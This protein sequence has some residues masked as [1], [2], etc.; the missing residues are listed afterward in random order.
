MENPH[1][2]P[3]LILAF[4]G[5]RKDTVWVTLVKAAGGGIFNQGRFFFKKIPLSEHCDLKPYP[6]PHLPQL[7]FRA[8]KTPREIQLR[9]W[10]VL[11]HNH[12]QQST[13]CSLEAHIQ[14]HE[15]IHYF[16]PNIWKAEVYRLWIWR[17]PF[18]VLTSNRHWQLCLPRTCGTVWK[19]ICACVCHHHFWWQWI[20]GVM[21]G[22]NKCSFLLLLLMLAF[23]LVSICVFQ[24]YLSHSPYKCHNF[25]NLYCVS[26]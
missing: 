10:R 26:Q 18:L 21:C 5:S 19:A 3:V 17:F 11:A 7:L 13:R 12:Q 24:W 6:F 1:P 4:I 15:K 9:N 2:P 23:N 14:G 20:S 25:R 16:P 8:W 22:M